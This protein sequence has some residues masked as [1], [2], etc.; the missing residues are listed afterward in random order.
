MKQEQSEEVLESFAYKAWTLRCK[1]DDGRE[2]AHGV[3]TGQA[4]VNSGISLSSVLIIGHILLSN[5][6]AE[7]WTRLLAHVIST[8]NWPT[9]Y[10]TSAVFG[11]AY[12]N[13]VERK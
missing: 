8:H 13:I 11:M 1:L 7:I 3:T 5:S 9:E 12:L 10:A 6:H 4:C 2:N